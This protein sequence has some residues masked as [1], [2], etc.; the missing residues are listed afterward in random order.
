V[1]LDQLTTYPS[2]HGTLIRLADAKCLFAQQGASQAPL[3]VRAGFEKWMSDRGEAANYAGDGMYESP[4]VN[5]KA[6]AFRA[7]VEYV[8]LARA[9]LPA[10]DREL[11]DVL[12]DMLA[13]QEACG[14]HT[15][16]YAPGSV[17]E[18]IKEMEGESV[19]APAQAGDAR[20]ARRLDL[21]LDISGF[22]FEIINQEWYLLDARGR[23]AGKG[24]TKRDAIDAAMSASQ[25]TKG[26]AA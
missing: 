13:I 20:D 5:R 3:D 10:K 18:Y 4:S 24:A 19:A 6:E 7:G 22:H 15:D 26:G 11:A 23:I 2:P 16:E 14:L 1:P 17:I 9:P 8:A 12:R 25:D 21:L